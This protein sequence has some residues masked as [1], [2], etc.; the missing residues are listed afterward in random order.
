MKH[1]LTVSDVV[2]LVS[3]ELSQVEGLYYGHGTENSD[4][5][6][7]FLVFHVC[8]LPFDSDE[9]V[10]S[11]AVSEAQYHHIQQLVHRRI[12]EKMP[13]PYLLNTAWFAGL[14]FYVDQRVLVPRSP[15][16]EIIQAQFEPWMDSSKIHRVLDLCTGSGCMAIAVAYA[17]P[18]AQIDAVDISTDA[19]AVAKRN[20]HD[21][22]LDHRIRLLESDVFSALSGQRYD[23]IISNPPYVDAEDMET[24]PEE[25]HHEPVIGLSSGGDGLDV[26]KKI[27]QHAK[28][29]LTSEGALMV[30]VGNS[31]PALEAQYPH[32]PF[33]WIDIHEGEDGIFV[34][35]HK[36]L[37]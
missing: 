22:H 2:D 6:A 20:I 15:F 19:L 5:E 18:H 13:M 26:T 9:R 1:T 14:K 28:D 24:L 23:L 8:A 11:K 12:T 7:Y 35:Y 31:F 36:D 21:H 10:W 4:D 37:I 25:Y 3:E 16:A 34:L 29:H 17:L 32:L 33:T 27:L 30:E